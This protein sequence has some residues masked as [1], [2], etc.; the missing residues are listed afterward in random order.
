MIR[1]ALEKEPC[2]KIS[3][4]GTSMLPTI[5]PGQTIWIARVRPEEIRPGDIILIQSSSSLVLHRLHRIEKREGASPVFITSGDASGKLDTPC[6]AESILAKV[7]KIQEDSGSGFL[8]K[9]SNGF[10]RSY[11]NLFAFPYRTYQRCV[12]KQWYGLLHRTVR[13]VSGGRP[14]AAPLMALFPMGSRAMAL[15]PLRR[16]LRRKAASLHRFLPGGTVE[17]RG[18]PDSV[19]PI[20]ELWNRSVPHPSGES[21]DNLKKEFL[22]ADLP[23]QNSFCFT[24]TR[25]GKTLGFLS[26]YGSSIQAIAVDP[27]FRRKGIGSALLEALLKEARRR[28]VRQL[29][30]SRNQGIFPKVEFSKYESVVLFFSRWGFSVETTWEGQLVCLRFAL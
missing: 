14:V 6:R 21:A 8:D 15:V 26:G 11:E 23:G 12:G 13:K 1:A 16:A 30:V 18:T 3:S 27:D 9:F 20:L 2:L 28:G 7:I 4:T 29:V 19:E 5:R 17:K 25:H 22:A 10:I 24:F